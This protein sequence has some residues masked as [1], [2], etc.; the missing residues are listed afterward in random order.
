MRG[1]ETRPGLQAMGEDGARPTPGF[2]A[3]I[4]PHTPPSQAFPPSAVMEKAPGL[5]KLIR[6]ID[7]EPNKSKGAREAGQAL[8]HQQTL[9]SHGNAPH[10]TVHESFC[11]SFLHPPQVFLTPVPLDTGLVSSLACEST[12]Y[13]KA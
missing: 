1:H 10:C 8:H 2:A 3:T 7:M 6:Q 5:L 11:R 4:T 12:F 13:A 9:V